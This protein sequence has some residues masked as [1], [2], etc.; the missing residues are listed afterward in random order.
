MDEKLYQGAF[1]PRSEE[2]K[3]RDWHIS[4]AVA[5]ASPVNWVEMKPSEVRQFGVQNQDGQLSCVAQTRRK[6]RRIMFKVNKGLDVDFSALHL[7]RRRFNYPDGGM[8][9]MDAVKIDRTFGMTLAPL[10]PSDGMSEAAANAVKIEPYMDEVAKIFKTENEFVFTAGDLE[11]IASTIQTT[12]KGVMVW[13]YFTSDEWSR[14]VPVVIDVS[15]NVYDARASRHSVAAVEPAIYQGKKGVWIEDSAHFGGLNRRFITEEFFKAR[16]FWA[17]Y[18]INLK[19]GAGVD[20]GTNKPVYT[21]TK[22]LVFIPL[23]PSGIISNIPLHEAQKAD[24]IALQNILKYEG[25]FALNIDST[26]YYGNITADAID[27][28]Q[29]KYQVAP[30]SEL[31]ALKGKRVGDKTI[32]KLNQLYGA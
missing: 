29:R 14:E 10:M 28:F 30:T 15:L 3:Q 12:R 25:L 17:S 31:D 19:F 4:E 32:Q 18:P 27:K 21:F 11:T 5:A 8:A 1:D 26:G 7:Y 6:L 23:S 24:V 16:N 13:F 2:E 22:P 20:T 9:A